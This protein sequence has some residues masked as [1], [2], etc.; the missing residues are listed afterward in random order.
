[1]AGPMK[2]HIRIRCPLTV[3]VVL[4]ASV[5]TFPVAGFAQTAAPESTLAKGKK[6]AQSPAHNLSGMYEFFARGVQG[7]GISNTV[8]ANPV[9]MTPWAQ[10]KY[11]AASQ[12]M[13]RKP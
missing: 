4:L 5:L 9:P 8:S 13:A 10:A 2:R 1:G 11:D 3:P 12:D 7:Q 6:A